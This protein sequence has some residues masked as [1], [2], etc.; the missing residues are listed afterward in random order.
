LE[1]KENSREF[2]KLAPGMDDEEELNEKATKE[3]IAQGEYT[4]VVALS[5][6]EVDP[7]T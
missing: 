6:D 4:K 2:P 1:R 7:S 3:E 5:F